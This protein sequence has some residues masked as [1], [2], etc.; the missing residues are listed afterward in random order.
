MNEF[1]RTILALGVASIFWD[2]PSSAV[3]KS[4][5]VGTDPTVAGD[6]AQII[7]VRARIDNACACGN[8]DGTPT[9]THRAYVACAQK[10]IAAESAAGRLRSQCKM[11]VK[12]YYSVSSCGMRTNVVRAPCITKKASGKVS[13]AVR[14][15]TRCVGPRQRACSGFATCVDA[16][17]TNGD[18]RI[19]AADSGSCLIETNDLEGILATSESIS[20]TI[21]DLMATSDADT[22]RGTVLAMLQTQ[23]YVAAAGL[24]DDVHSVWVTFSNGLGGVFFFG[25]P[26]TLGFPSSGSTVVASPVMR[27]CTGDAELD[28]G[29]DPGAVRDT[30]RASRSLNQ[31]WIAWPLGCSMINA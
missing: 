6:R 28:C 19:T 12:R 18:G 2:T 8:Y 15:I 9:K 27:A 17:D 16:A 14:P 21:D 7:G 4:C 20:N 22:A 10:V 31:R 1:K 5:L 30:A 13:C 11:T 23:P 29:D 26:G 3:L 24:S 25:P